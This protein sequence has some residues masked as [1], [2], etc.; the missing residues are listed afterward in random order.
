M[1]IRLAVERSE[2]ASSATK[3][4]GRVAVEASLPTPQDRLKEIATKIR[5][6][7]G[8]VEAAMGVEATFRGNV[9]LCLQFVDAL[10]AAA[11]DDQ[12]RQ[13]AILAY[14]REVHS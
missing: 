9:K 10:A 4:V 8:D 3:R 2:M 14:L 5:W 11:P 7:L 12:G 13:N 1:C 6:Q